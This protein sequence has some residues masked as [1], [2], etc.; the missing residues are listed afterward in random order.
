VLYTAAMPTRI[1]QEIV[2]IGDTVRRLRRD[3]G[4]TQAQLADKVG[5]TQSA[6]SRLE[7]GET[8]DPGQ[9]L[10]ARIAEA[11]TV[12]IAEVIGRTTDPTIPIAEIGR[13]PVPIVQVP[14]H[15]GHDWTWQ[16]TG[17]V[18][19]IDERSSWGKDLQAIRVEGDCMRPVLEPGDIVIFDRWS[20]DPKDREIVVVSRDSQIHVRW[21]RIRRPGAPLEL[22]DNFGNHFTLDGQTVLEGVVIETRR[23]RPR[24]SDWHDF[25]D[26][27]ELA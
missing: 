26:D 16:P 6:I 19:T 5:V 2:P 23:P 21:A 8:I 7:K 9:E 11:F 18:V 3:R 25:E 1:G 20:R 17:Q 27:P 12:P 13:I 10:V 15:A 4:W 24:R 22:V 14:A